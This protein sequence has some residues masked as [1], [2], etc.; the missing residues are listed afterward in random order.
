MPLSHN[1]PFRLLSDAYGLVKGFYRMVLAERASD[2][3]ICILFRPEDPAHRRSGGRPTSVASKRPNQTRKKP[4]V[5]S[6]SKISY[7]LF[8]ELLDNK[9][10]VP[11]SLEL[12]SSYYTDLKKKKDQEVFK[13][14]CLTMQSFLD[15][16]QL[17][18]SILIHGNIGE[19]VRKTMEKHQVSNSHVRQLWSILCTYGFTE[20]SLRARWDRCGAPGK[21]RLLSP[22]ASRQKSGRKTSQQRLNKA[23]YGIYGQPVQ[24]GMNEAWEDIIAAA[25]KKVPIPKPSMPERYKQIISSHFATASTFDADG[26]IITVDLKKGSYPNYQQV[27]RVLTTRTNYLQKI[28]EKTSKGHFS[29]A[30]RGL[31]SKS[32]EGVSGPGHLYAIDSTIGDIYLR[33]SLN[34]AWIVG[35]PIV[36]I[37]VD[38]WSTAIVGF[39]V[40]LTGPSWST[41]QVSLFNTAASAQLLGHLWDYE[42]QPSLFPAPT[43]PYALQCDRGEYLSKR[44]KATGMKLS[45]NLSYA[46]PFRPDLKG[47]VEV[48][49]RILKNTQYNFL[50]GAMDARRAEYD[51]RRSNPAEATMTVRHY[52]QYLHECFFRYNLT[53]NRSHR[54]DAHMMADHVYPSPAG[55]WR[56]GHAM[57]IGYSKA[58][59]QAELTSSLLPI[60]DKGRVSRSGISFCGNDY[61]SEIIDAEQWSTIARTSGHGWQIPVQYYPGSVAKIWTPNVSGKGLIDLDISDLARTS[62]EVT[63]D[64]MADAFAYQRLRAADIEHENLVASVLALKRMQ[65]IKD[66]SI[67]QTRIALDRARGRQP[68]ITEARAMEVALQN[69]QT[70]AEISGTRKIRS[71]ANV[72]HLEMMEA[73]FGEMNEGHFHE[74]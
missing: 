12:H 14:R 23:L 55:L 31:S 50:P 67:E 53:A 73:L 6:L 17:R 26:K 42:M 37:V 21:K 56:W 69:S 49:H 34:P 58:Q 19:L 61:R 46:P 65:A 41:A 60:S 11:Q 72:H 63:H 52:M 45:V 33:S 28:L 47:V 7:Q 36:Y 66:E 54:L 10:I 1:Q 44:A 74:K 2:A 70:V 25:D 4:L 8:Q 18:E 29:R 48:M 3:V 5:G 16:E 57:G 38:V 68:N 43:L 24:T 62:P 35:R 51:L 20:R 39:Y 22:N 64:E 13:S 40:C 59:A 15:F 30:L 9:E 27:K 71:E 32:W